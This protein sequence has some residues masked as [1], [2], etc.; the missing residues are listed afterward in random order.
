MANTYTAE[1][2]D[3]MT[4]EQLRAL[5]PADID[6]IVAEARRQQARALDTTRRYEPLTWAS[7]WQSFKE[8]SACF[9]LFF[10]GLTAYLLLCGLLPLPGPA[11]IAMGG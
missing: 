5:S 11:A 9:A 4:P 6:Q 10:L 7:W 8:A 3:A 2:V 1:Q